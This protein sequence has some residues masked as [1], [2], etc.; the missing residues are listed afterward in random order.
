MSRLAATRAVAHWAWRMFRR[1][2]RGQVLVL[3]LL[4][5]AVAVASYGA[6]FGHA[7][8]PGDQAAFGSA[9]GRIDFTTRDQGAALRAVTL[10]SRRLGTVDEITDEVVPIPGSVRE[11]DLRTQ[12]PHGAFGS[13]LLRLRAG[14]YPTRAGEIALTPEM[15][16][17]LAAPV[18]ASITLDGVARRVVGQVENPQELD[19][20]FGLVTEVPNTRPIHYT[21][22]VAAS[23]TRLAAFRAAATVPGGITIDAPVYYSHDLGVLLVA[24]LGMMLVA[25]IALTAFLVLAQRRVR[26]LGMLAAIGATRRQVRNVTVIHG[27]IVGAISAVLGT[28]TAWAGW[29]L[30]SSVIAQVAGRRVSWN[31]VPVWL[32]I[33]P[34]LM[35]VLA[36]AV[37]AW[38]P[39][40]VMARVP[41]VRALADRPP[42]APRSR[43][44]A[45]LAGAALTVGVVSLRFAH[46]RNALLM[47]VGLAAMIGAILFTTPLAIRALTAR[48]RRLPVAGRLAWR[49]LGRNQS[50]SA[51]ALATV[52]FAIGISVA[53]VVV[54]AAN[55]HPPSA[56]NL[57][58]R[59]ILISATDSRDPTV[60]PARSNR[61][62]AALDA[63]AVRVA[64]TLPSATLVPLS[65]AVDPAAPPSRAAAAIGGGDAAQ[66]V[67]QDGRQLSSFPLYLATGRLLAAFGVATRLSHSSYFAINPKGTWSLLYSGRAPLPTPAALHVDGYTSLPQVLVSPAVAAAHHWR[68]G[69]AGWLLQNPT[70]LNDAQ[71]RA[72]RARAAQAGLA[73]EIRDPQTYLGRLKWMF[74]AGGIV[75]TL[76][77]IAIA[78]VLLRIQTT[79]DQQILTAVGAPSRVRRA[80]ATT[81][82]AALAAVGAVLG[83]LGAYVTLIMAYSDTLGRLSNVP[84]S[85]LATLGLGIPVL[86][87]VTTWL[88]TSRQPASINRPAFD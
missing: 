16:Q 8:A 46:Q 44:S 82:A 28:A 41:V 47:I 55:T 48:S 14:R 35:G 49:E 57:S 20:S 22:L 73:I 51:A 23:A 59:Q 2:W 19:A 69:R 50:R 60:V 64:A 85:A 31:A 27:L 30:T 36:S 65:V 58:D 18:G 84:W 26:Q 39:A 37:A 56:G 66:A 6:A 32:L 87:L 63:A 83:I 71:E 62:R 88:T 25:V 77:V 81:T 10:A 38:W 43:R 11:L 4:T 12:D 53:A 7:L 79:R 34:G 74:A 3:V 13:S 45:T 17:F 72:V 76:A 80:I 5:V 61:Q 52:T 29:A 54:T 21:L 68:V 40:R 42:D 33:T 15:S 9:T 75:V 86:A 24:A 67:R 70:P 1:E 78:L